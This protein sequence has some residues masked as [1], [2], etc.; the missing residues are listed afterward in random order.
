MQIAVGTDHAG[1]EGPPLFK[2]EI[3]RHLE[4]RGHR[5]IDCG[6]HGPEPVDYPDFA[7]RVCRTIL[8]GDAERGVLLCGTGIGMSIAANRFSGIRAAACATP[9]MARLAREHNDANVICLGRRILTLAQCLELI[10]IWLDTEFS[11][12]E[13][14][15]RRVTKMG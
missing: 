9:D 12:A 4:E 6:P 10:D 13:R 2:P 15:Q 7:G 8:D 11:G 3:I 14:H 1:Y 5:V